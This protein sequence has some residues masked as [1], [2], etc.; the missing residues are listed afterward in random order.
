M[1]TL[2]ACISINL[3]YVSIPAQTAEGMCSSLSPSVLQWDAMT[4]FM[5]CT[6]WQLLKIVEE[7]VI[8]SIFKSQNTCVWNILIAVLFF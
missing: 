7:E 8:G 3:M 2:D 6:V 1:Q 4:T 5:D